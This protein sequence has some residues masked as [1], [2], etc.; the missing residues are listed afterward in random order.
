MLTFYL[1]KSKSGKKD[2]IFDII[3]Q[4]ASNKKDVL[5]IVPEQFSFEAEK[6]TLERIDAK[7]TSY[8]SVFNF[9]SLAT[10]IKR[11]Y[12][13]NTAKIIDNSA[14]IMLM[15]KAIKSVADELCFFKSKDNS[16]NS[17][18]TISNAV[19]E[20]KQQAITT[21][22]LF[23]ASKSIGATAL[24]MKLSDL[25]KIIMAYDALL[26]ETYIDPVDELTFAYNKIKDSGYFKDKH[27]LFYGFSNFTG[28]Q[29]KIINQAISECTDSYFSLCTDGDFDDE[30]SVFK[31]VNTTYAKLSALAKGKNVSI[32]SDKLENSNYVGAGLSDLEKKLSGDEFDASNNNAISAIVADTKYDELEYVASHIHKRVR[33]EGLRYRD[34]TIVARNPSEYSNIAGG[35]FKNA[36]VPLFVDEKFSFSELPIA[37][38]I[39]SALKASRSFKTK[40][41]YRYLKSGLTDLTVEEINKIDNYVYLWGI[42]TKDWLCDFTKN[43]FGLQEKKPNEINSSLNELNILR[44]K[45]ISPLIPL[46]KIKNASGEEFCYAVFSFLEAINVSKNL[47]NYANSIKS[48]GDGDIEQYLISG[49]KALNE[50]LQNIFECYENDELSFKEFYE[51]LILCFANISIGAIPQ[52]LDQV[53]LISADR[54]VSLDAKHTYILGL[55]YGKFPAEFKNNGIFNNKEKGF[56]EGLNINFNDDYIANCIEENFI[57]YKAITSAT[58]SVCLVAAGSDYNASQELSPLFNDVVN[59]FNINKLYFP[60]SDNMYA[61]AETPLQIINAAIRCGDFGVLKKMLDEDIVNE[62]VKS[63]IKQ[64]LSADTATLKSIN[65]KVAKMVY[66]KELNISPSKLEQ[67][68]KCPYSY[69]FKYGL[70]ITQRDKIDFKFMQRGTIAHYVLEKILLNDFDDLSQIDMNKIKDLIDSYIKEYITSTVGGIELLDGEGNYLLRRIA[71]ML[72]D[73][74]PYVVNELK[75][76]EFKPQKFELKVGDDGEIAPITI[77]ENDFSAKIGGIVDRVDVAEIDGQAYIRIVDYKTGV[78]NFKFSDILFGLNLQ[79]LIYLCAICED[80]KLGKN[81]AAV[82]YQPLNHI[83]FSGAEKKSN[84]AAKSKGIVL[85]DTEVIKAM[86]PTGMYMPVSFNVNGCISKS[87]LTLQSEEFKKVFQYVKQKF[88]EMC[89]RLIEGDITPM[90]CNSDSQHLAC[91]WCDYKN[92]CGRTNEDESTTVKSMSKSEFIEEIERGLSNG[93]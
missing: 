87:S 80:G 83:A 56:L 13:G 59:S 30:F 90:P 69:L 26:G 65:S 82:I 64:I 48:C 5:L 49:W 68:Y 11:I 29:Y 18:L 43:P 85:E 16:L 1:G 55:N 75:L 35:I 9:S 88:S 22:Q 12:G 20:I 63:L 86:D 38:V 52:G 45:I 78:K 40:D 61:Y 27:I 46:S 33:T 92:I 14:R 76:S 50:T 91:T 44:K 71:A 81:P 42:D 6:E 54:I 37:T 73:L 24:G 70:K 34:F 8:V 25:A 7:Y 23:N 19:T 28:Q 67:F 66:G 36:N 21:K 84:N 10:E 79:M 31:N 41:I 17:I 74:V 39:K 57:A 2:K 93:N 89:N 51:I 62:D 72:Y 3:F 15:H 58:H 32:A 47:T 4:L 60:N 53:N 77:K